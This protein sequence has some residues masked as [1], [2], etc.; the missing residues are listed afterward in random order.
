MSVIIFREEDYAVGWEALLREHWLL[1]QKNSQES[2]K[3]E[4]AF[5]FGSCLQAFDTQSS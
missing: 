1:E 5:V 2:T 3:Q 4:I